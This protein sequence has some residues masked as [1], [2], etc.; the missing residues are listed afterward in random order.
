MD[1]PVIFIGTGGHAK[2]VL[3]LLKLINIKIIGVVDPNKIYG[4]K[5]LGIDV[6]GDD[7]AVLKYDKDK[8]LLVNGIGYMPKSN[9]RHT[10]DTNFIKHG[11]RFLS[12]THPTSIVSKD[13]TLGD[14]VQIMAG[15]IIQTGVTL[16]KS[17]IINTGSIIDHDCMIE[18][19]VHISSGT[20]ICGDVDIGKNTFVGANS[21]VVQNIKIGKN[22]II[23][24]GSV[25][26]KNINNNQKI[27]QKRDEHINLIEFA[28]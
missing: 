10:L 17:T 11:Y 18:D 8:I 12:I 3:D 28:Q 26:H 7:S 5:W 9:L 15:S 21:V 6:L 19:N 2:V 13:V 1:K 16:G 24:A 22:C 4:E 27:V 20:T 23:S 25:I 14:G